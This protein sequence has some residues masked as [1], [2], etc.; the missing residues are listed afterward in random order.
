VA[1]RQ[2]LWLDALCPHLIAVRA[3]ISG[4]SGYRP[5]DIVFIP[6]SAYK[7]ENLVKVPAVESRV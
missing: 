4:H 1:S 5:D 3:C 6:C 2:V 7:G